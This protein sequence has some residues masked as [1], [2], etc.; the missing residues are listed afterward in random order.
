MQATNEYYRL[1]QL[2]EVSHLLA[3]QKLRSTNRNPA[4]VY[5]IQG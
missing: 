3:G 1:M 2:T 5:H 4:T